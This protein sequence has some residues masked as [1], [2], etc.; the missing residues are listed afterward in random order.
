LHGTF[1]GTDAAGLL[2]ELARHLPGASEGLGRISKQ[3]VNALMRDNGNYT[4]EYGRLFGEALRDSACAA[5]TPMSGASVTVKMLDWTGENHHLGRA[6]AAVRLVDELSRTPLSPGKRL[7]V[8]G[9]SHGGNVAALATRLLAGEPEEVEAFFSAARCYFR[10]LWFTESELSLW[11]KVEQM[12]RD[13]AR[14]ALPHRID[15]A[16]FGTPLRYAW[17][18]A[19]TGRIV[20][21]VNHRPVPGLP[22]HR[23][24][25]PRSAADVLNAVGGDYIQQLGI[26]GSN[27]AP[28]FWML[29]A[30][31]ADL[32]LHRLLQP[33]NV[34]WRNL[35]ERICEG[36]R[37]AEAGRTLLVDYGPPSDGIEQHLAGHAVY[38]RLA[39]LPFHMQLTAQQLSETAAD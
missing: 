18:E 2:T 37:T 5:T 7:L 23:T 1:A 24:A 14:P 26:A 31:L 11:P 39:W 4:P 20:H 36:V 13:G 29:R 10:R 8:W 34:N 9:H 22:E 27:V 30:W 16:T 35:W 12:L 3:L 32:R 25:A 19:A 28:P 6:H 21:F 17:C 33:L 15:V 38:T